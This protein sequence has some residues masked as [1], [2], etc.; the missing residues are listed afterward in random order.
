MRTRLGCAVHWH[1]RSAPPVTVLA[2]VFLAACASVP[3]DRGYGDVRQLAAD[4]GQV[5]PDAV[6]AD[7]SALVQEILTRPL[8]QTN[9]VRVAFINNPRLG[10][11]YARLGLTGAEVIQAGRLSNP[12]FTGGW[13]Y[14]SRTGDVNRYDLGLTQNFVEL[15]LL[16]ARTRFAKGEFERAKLD[17][18]QDLLNLAADV[19]SAYYGAVGARQVTE[20]RKTIAT[21]AASSAELS[22]RFQQA[23]N[24]T[25]LEL[26][27]DQATASQAMLDLEQAE[28][29][30]TRADNRLNELMGLSARTHWK[31]ANALPAPV[32]EEDTL[33]TLQNL[34]TTKRPDLDSD[35]RAVALLE[36]SLGITRRYRFLGS[37]EV[38]VQYERDT[39]RNRLLGPSF[40]L[41]LPIFSQGQ[42]PLLRAE[43]QLDAA[44]A[45][46]K[47]KE[48]E[49]FNGVQS[50]H[51]HVM[52]ARK[53][54]ER[55]GGET[56]PLREK[57]V[58]R[59][60]EQVSYMLV[61]IFELLRAK[62]NEYNAYEQ[63]LEAVRD[64]WDARVDL[65]R[66][67]GSRL[68]SDSLIGEAILAPEVPVEP[69]SAGMGQMDHGA[70]MSMPGMNMGGMGAGTGQSCDM[71]GMD[72]S[73]ASP[74]EHQKMM[75]QCLEQQNDDCEMKDM[76][77][78]KMSAEEQRKMMAQCRQ[79]PGDAKPK[80][81]S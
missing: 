52:A 10:A 62:Q 23:G 79:K 29:D 64:Y 22:A 43:S 14:S 31:V 34:A 33:D 51:D 57:I 60:Q 24:F 73:K 74:G 7:R 1:A 3:S 47:A 21:A 71:A 50:A 6:A 42:A 61:G 27:L 20:M 32:G 4:R 59:T 49:V 56:I 9:A 38:G 66:A 30:E 41:Q 55:L 45:E 28:A 13:Q 53:R 58:A 70:G 39:D 65:A 46:L 67:I 48:L 5:L 63:Y 76:D 18:T 72:M 78:S 8:T 35:R 40:S 77:M 26:A 19:Q 69:E 54:V 2:A 80:G 25:A 44:R 17:A 36:D 11:D 75:A 15:L 37:A 81:G 68:P 16:P 12:T